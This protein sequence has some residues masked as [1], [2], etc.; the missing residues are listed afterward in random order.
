MGY[1]RHRYLIITVHDCTGERSDRIMARADALWCAS[2]SNVKPVRSGVGINGYITIVC[3]PSGSK[4]GWAEYEWEDRVL[5][6]MLAWLKA[7]RDD[8]G[9]PRWALVEWDEE[10]GWAAIDHESDAEDE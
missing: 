3:P 10:T 1:I 8:L 9:W 2:K 6:A 5:G 4:T 7:N